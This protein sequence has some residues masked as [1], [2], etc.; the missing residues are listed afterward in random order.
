MTSER[1][2]Q[3]TPVTAAE[4]HY[5]VSTSGN[6]GFADLN[7][8]CRALPTRMGAA[9]A[10]LDFKDAE[11]DMV[12]AHS[13]LLTPTE[14]EVLPV[15]SDRRA[16]FNGRPVS[17]EENSYRS[18]S[19]KFKHDLQAP[20]LP[21]RYKARGWLANT[22]G[23]TTSLGGGGYALATSAG[24]SLLTY[25]GIA[26]VAATS[27]ALSVYNTRK[28][29]G[30]ARRNASD[31]LNSI[32]AKLKDSK[33]TGTIHLPMNAI[34]TADSELQE[35]VPK[36][37]EGLYAWIKAGDSEVSIDPNHLVG[38]TLGLFDTAESLVSSEQDGR[39]ERLAILIQEAQD[40]K[41]Q[42]GH[43]NKI[44]ELT[45]IERAS[46]IR[47]EYVNTLL[48]AVALGKEI[49]VVNGE[50]AD[51]LEQEQRLE[52][53]KGLINGIVTEAGDADSPLM[54]QMVELTGVLHES[55]ASS[56]LAQDLD[57]EEVH[58]F[59]NRLNTYL[60]DMKQLFTDRA[61]MQQFYEGLGKQ[62]SGDI[63]LPSWDEVS[64]RFI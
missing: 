3:S 13:W 56:R 33:T 39:L 43:Q 4:M 1:S 55:L 27:G 63:E 8:A 10:R 25:G 24:A 60:S 54:M 38:I 37:T 5:L 59:L 23:L 6:E 29:R 22:T 52:E 30:A 58:S 42:H 20:K 40:L 41:K 18:V 9:V 17:F 61:Q 7:A 36:K 44:D 19:S 11:G 31:Y 57:S 2:M 28:A 32:T 14:L 46:S 53:S 12:S 16:D 50:R 35:V 62:F 47:S 64:D 49:S 34:K 45:G 51:I 21:L 15:I 26:G 48:G